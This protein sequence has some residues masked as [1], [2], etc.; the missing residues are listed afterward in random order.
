M[1]RK[2]VAAI[3]YQKNKFLL[4][5]RIAI[6]LKSGELESI[7]EEWDLIKGGIEIN[8]TPETTILRELK[9]ETGTD[10]YKIISVFENKIDYDLPEK[11]GFEKQETTVF[12]VEFLGE[13]EE[14]KK[15]DSEVGHLTFFTKQEA[16]E[17]IKYSETKNYFKK[18]APNF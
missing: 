13:K 1:I 2:S 9:E 4:G 14:L 3:I 7:P 17:K 15:Q 11:T 16:I 5:S 12:L 18:Y 10:K 6:L 8:E